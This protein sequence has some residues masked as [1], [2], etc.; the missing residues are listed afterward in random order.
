MNITGVTIPP[1]VNRYND[2]SKFDRGLFIPNNPTRGQ[3]ARIKAARWIT[4]GDVTAPG[5]LRYTVEYFSQIPTTV[6]ELTTYLLSTTEE[7]E[8][9]CLTRTICD[10]PIVIEGF[11]IKHY[12]TGAKSPSDSEIASA[13][14]LGEDM[15]KKAFGV[16]LVSAQTILAFSNTPESPL[17]LTSASITYIAKM[18]VNEK[19]H[20]VQETLTPEFNKIRP[21]YL[22]MQALQNKRFD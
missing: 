11:A 19:T 14:S 15:I 2:Y 7:I 10:N 5:V 6:E 16:G 18:T 9:V 20:T 1:N 8:H 3:A 4:A 12:L 17:A 21:L 13:L 22:I